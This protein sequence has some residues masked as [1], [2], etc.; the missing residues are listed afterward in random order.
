MS[1]ISFGLADVLVFA[2]A[3]AVSVVVTPLVRNFAVRRRIGNK[4]N[5]RDAHRDAIPHLGGIALFLGV[6]TAM[7]VALLREN[8][9]TVTGALLVRS[10]PALLLIVVL[11]LVDDTRSLPARRKLAFQLLASASVVAVGFRL[12][13]GMWVFDAATV[14]LLVVSL[15]F[16]VGMLSSVNLVDGHDGLAAGVTMLSAVAFAVVGA[17]M[18]L[19][20]VVALALA[21]GGACLGFLVFNFPP[22]RIYMGDTGSMLLGLVLS[23]AACLIS[24]RAPS[25]N[26]FAAVC[27]ALGVPL[28]DTMLAIA[29]R[30]VLRSPLF[31]AD[32]LHMHHVLRDAG[33][34]PRR[35]LMVLYAMQAFFSLLGVGAAM[36]WMLPVIVGLG[37]VTVAFVSF[38]RMMVEG[39]ETPETIPHR[40]VPNTIPFQSS[41]STNIPERRT[42]VGR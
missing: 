31:G 17:M 29:R 25:V 37:F 14:S 38:L 21:T 41:F 40:A 12:F 15:V 13:T 23:L 9:L 7:T 22:G 32:R 34:S 18:G 30:V 35:T 8:S 10:A 6:A 1:G 24:M 27:L 11:G 28:L 19:P 2:T 33:L 5:G 16:I 42:S 36:G 39:R 4:P 26:T 20:E 3:L